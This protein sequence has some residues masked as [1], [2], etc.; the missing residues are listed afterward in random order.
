M[1]NYSDYLHSFTIKSEWKW[2]THRLRMLQ[3][4]QKRVKYKNSRSYILL[5]I[6]LSNDVETNPGPVVH[7]SRCS[8]PFDRQSRLD[9]HLS[10]QQKVKCG[11]CQG[12]FCSEVQVRQHQRTDH[13]IGMSQSFSCTRCSK[14]FD[15]KSRLDAHLEQQERIVC[16]QCHGKFC[17]KT[18]VTTFFN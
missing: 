4:R 8:K 11:Q 7:C 18:Q 1:C 16:G 10:K 13:G 2:S 12:K 6:L 17:R 14:T 5:L 3:R 9:N 15:R